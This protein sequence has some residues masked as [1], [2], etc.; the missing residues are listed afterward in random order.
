MPNSKSTIKVFVSSTSEDLVHHREAVQRAILRRGMLPVMAELFAASSES[1]V[2]AVR[3][4]LSEC[5]VMVGIYA[6]RYGGVAP[7]QD[8]SI[9]ELE[10]NWAREQGIDCLLFVLDPDEGFP[11][12]H[13]IRT[14]ADD[15]PR[16]QTF[17]ER[18]AEEHHLQKFGEPPDLAMQVSLALE[19]WEKRG[20]QSPAQIATP[21]PTLAPHP[22]APAESAPTSTPTTTTDTEY[23]LPLWAKLLR[24]TLSIVTILI[25][26]NFL[27]TVLEAGNETVTIFSGLL[28]VILTILPLLSSY[29]GA[30]EPLEALSNN[31]LFQWS[32]IGA[33]AIALVIV[34]LGSQ[35]LL[36]TLADNQLDEAFSAG[37]VAEAIN[38]LDSA[39]VLGAEVETAVREN[40]YEFVNA[41]SITSEQEGIVLRNA[42][43]YARYAS[44]AE[45]QEVATDLLNR[46]LAAA[47]TDEFDRATVLTSVIV[48]ID[49]DTAGILIGQFNDIATAA[50]FEVM[51]PDLTAARK[52]FELV[53]Q[54]DQSVDTARTPE[55]QSISRYNLAVVA[56]QQSAGDQSQL[57]EVIRFYDEAIELNDRNIEARYALSSLLLIEFNQNPAQLE[58]TV[59]LA[60]QGHERYVDPQYCS[61]THDLQNEDVFLNA[62]YCFLLRTTEA[63]A[64]IALD[65]N[66]NEANSLVERAI[67]LAEANEQF[68]VGNYT[69]EAYYYKAL[70]DGPDVSCETLF[71]IIT[72]RDTGNPRHTEW[73]IYANE[74]IDASGC[75]P[76]SS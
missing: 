11:P 67:R 6:N 54:I 17:L 20:D 52:Y 73:A 31:R 66:T 16:L 30:F 9:V 36:D 39:E 8:A 50:A 34:I 48:I 15:D 38:A 46:A 60:G 28:G 19:Q 55:Q 53:R 43:L 24:L 59:E 64:L 58:R 70:L 33:Q 44:N 2:E 3:R 41:P 51:P 4:E 63:G 76:T 49:P 74:Q 12:K 35:S 42:E 32:I 37:S 1:R 29:L 10:Y 14:E 22:S 47:A 21:P 27:L 26:G 25:I 69:A 75:S 13:P 61:G 68:G 62:W 65:R 5:D 40:L 23:E 57:N 72:N 45:Q 18:I 56:E 71:Q 7:G